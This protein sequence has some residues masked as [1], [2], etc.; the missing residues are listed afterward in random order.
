[1]SQINCLASSHG[2]SADLHGDM[3]VQRA[4]LST[5]TI[6]LICSFTAWHSASRFISSAQ[7]HGEEFARKR[8]HAFGAL[9]VLPEELSH[10]CA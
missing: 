5:V 8:A 2:N 10:F 1:M 4:T 3:R 9:R 7:E 6:I